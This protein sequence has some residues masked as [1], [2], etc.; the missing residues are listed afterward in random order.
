[1]MYQTP[2]RKGVQWLYAA[3]MPIL[4]ASI[5]I[6]CSKAEEST[7]VTGRAGVYENPVTEPEVKPEY[8]GGVMALMTEIANSVVYPESAKE[9]G[10][11]GTVMVKFTVGTDGSVGDVM[12]A[13]GVNEALDQAAVDATKELQKFTPGTVGGEPVAVTMVLPV[14]FQLQ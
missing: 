5:L 14:K 3:I 8:P 11:E 2:S 1:M 13:R 10:A 6:A 7:E 4:A 12:I 9:A